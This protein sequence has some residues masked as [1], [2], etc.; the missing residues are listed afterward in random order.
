MHRVALIVGF[1]ECERGDGSG[2][3]G[4]EESGTAGTGGNEKLTAL[5]DVDAMS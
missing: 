2:I 4:V 3:A 5:G 1:E